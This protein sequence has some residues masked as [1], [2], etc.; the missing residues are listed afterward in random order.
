[1]EASRNAAARWRPSFGRQVSGGGGEPVDLRP[2]RRK[3]SVLDN[4]PDPPELSLEGERADLP[5][6]PV[7]T[8]LLVA[9]GVLPLWRIA[10]FVSSRLFGLK[11]PMTLRFS[12][13][14]LSVHER[15]EVSGRVL[16]D[17]ERWIA[18]ENLATI[19]REESHSRL[20]LYVGIVALLSGTY[21]GTR[22]LVDGL[23]VPDGSLRLMGSGLL[24]I[25]FGAIV[26]FAVWSARDSV[27]SRCRL[28][29]VPHRGRA[30]CC[31]SVQRDKADAALR[32]V[33]TGEL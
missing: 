32:A 12:K 7:S 20:G 33:S 3:L 5:R 8:A 15:L 25:A 22:D 23:A 14:G 28:I 27:R 13:N 31:G 30:F 16:R 1:M 4:V 26:D 11:R 24:L 18:R 29:V 10:R 17:T 9:T 19:T 2:R 6:G 21:L